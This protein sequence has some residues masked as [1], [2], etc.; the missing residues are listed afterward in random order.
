M[1]RLRFAAVFWVGMT[2][3]WVALEAKLAYAQRVH[4]EAFQSGAGSVQ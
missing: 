2:W 3:L 1:T 4:T